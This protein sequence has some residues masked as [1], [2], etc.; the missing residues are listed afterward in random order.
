MWFQVIFM[1]IYACDL[2]TI[3]TKAAAVSTKPKSSVIEIPNW[4][5]VQG[6]Q[7]QLAGKT[8]SVYLGIPYAKPPTG[9]L[10]FASE[11][12]YSSTMLVL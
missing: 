9:R 4:G 12:T 7:D 3:S 11:Y 2:H 1:M 10:R 8:V 6:Y 5:K